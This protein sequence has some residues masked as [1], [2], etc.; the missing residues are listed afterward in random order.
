M[1]HEGRK[2]KLT[3][4]PYKPSSKNWLGSD[5]RGVDNLSK[6]VVTAKDTILLV[7][8]IT[9]VRYA[10]GVPLGLIARKKRGSPT[11][12]SPL[13]PAVLLFAAGLRIRAAA[14]A[15]VLSLLPAA[16]GL[17]HSDSG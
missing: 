15:S 11:G 14:C 2:Q 7:L 10:I 3:L 6:L 8:A 4:P 13:E 5:K 1:G 12:S 16:D 17:G 9:A